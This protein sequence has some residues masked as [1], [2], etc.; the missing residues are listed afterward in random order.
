M[1]FFARLPDFGMERLHIDRWLLGL[2]V[3]IEYIDGALQ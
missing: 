1:R 3:G 2:A